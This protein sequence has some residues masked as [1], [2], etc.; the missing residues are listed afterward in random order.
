MTEI[1]LE[2]V[3]HG[4]SVV[5]MTDDKVVFVTGG[6][7]GELVVVDI[8]EHS[9]RFDRGRVLEVVE[10]VAGRVTPP[11]PIAERCGGCDW[12][13]ASPELQLDLKTAV[14]AE[15]LHRLAG[16][17]WEGRV[18]AV[19]PTT[20]WRTRMRYAVDDAGRVGLRARR[21]HDVVP[22]PEQGCLVA[23]PGPDLAELTRMAA[24][25]ESLEVV[26][27]DDG[28][29]VL[30]DGVRLRGGAVV[31]QSVSG[32][33]F[34]VD[35][36]GFWQVHPRAAQVLTDAVLHGLR[37]TTGETALDLYCGVGLFA[38]PLAAAGCDVLGI[39]GSR[40]AIV[41]ARMN[42][43]G[44]RFVA[45]S[46]EKSLASLPPRADVVVLDPPRKGAGATV[47]KA[48]ARLRPRAIAYV[49]CDPSALGRDLSTFA[50]LGFEPTSIEAFDLFPMTHHVECVAI[51]EPTNRSRGDTAVM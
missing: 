13:H 29:S 48:I 50:S 9:Q 25:A 27:S 2:R 8:T 47:V 49:A 30:A 1:R 23:A 46:L 24:G 45:G 22:L 3:A 16:I 41:R 5:G 20:G 44:A 12:Q 38:A 4:G 36:G 6:L 17:T 11:C 32:H 37:P 34:A 14:V 35:A 39:E 10:P 7:P 33:R 43:P 51:L 26:V 18:Q 15:Q 31:H 19:A 21:S 28:V 42:V 40:R